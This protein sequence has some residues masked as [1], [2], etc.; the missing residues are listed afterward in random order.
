MIY[1][2]THFLPPLL[3]EMSEV[4]PVLHNLRNQITERPK[5]D[6]NSLSVT[7]GG[8]FEITSVLAGLVFIPSEEIM[9]PRNST[10][11]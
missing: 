11:C 6:L 3:K 7:G 4:L 2:W 5:N 1:F 9:K 10:D 8:I